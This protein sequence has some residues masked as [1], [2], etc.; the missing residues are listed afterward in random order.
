M[1][2]A[3][4]A[5][6]RRQP[7][8]GSA[9]G[10]NSMGQPCRHDSPIHRFVTDRCDADTMHRMFATLTVLLAV[11]AQ[12][13]PRDWSTAPA[14]VQLDTAEDI[15][16]MGDVHGDR[17]RLVELLAGA[18]VIESAAHP[19]WTAGRA[20]LVFTGDLIDKG[21]DAV[22]VITLLRALG[23]EATAAGG[24]VVVLMGNHEAEFLANPGASKGAEFG[25]QLSAAGLQPHEVG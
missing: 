24:R 16:A 25:A 8:E 13:A 7:P 18:G 10:R 22:G 12:A 5:A 3:G 17:Q 6:A 11:A 1:P 19:V 23:T 15:F 4:S 14:I 21:P 20:V 2:S 9:A